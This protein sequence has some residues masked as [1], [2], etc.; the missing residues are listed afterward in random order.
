MTRSIEELV[1]FGHSDL[2]ITN[3]EMLEALEMVH[4]ITQVLSRLPT[5]DMN[6]KITISNSIYMVEHRLSALNY[7]SMTMRGWEYD[8]AGEGDQFDLSEALG[9]ATQMYLHLA[10]RSIHV[11]AGRHQRPFRRIYAALPHDYN[12]NSLVAPRLYLCLLLWIL[13]IGAVD[14]TN[15][16]SRA[17]YIRSLSQL[18]LP[19]IILTREDL[20]TCLREVLWMESFSTEVADKIWNDLSLF[21]SQE[22]ELYTSLENNDD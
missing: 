10:I 1:R 5:L 9:L 4:A 14:T 6:N 16:V 3:R 19:L 21:W 8:P 18:C 12:F 22:I 11:R 2:I 13:S 7:R 15:A 17:F 20:E